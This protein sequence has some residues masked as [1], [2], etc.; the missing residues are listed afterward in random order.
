[1]RNESAPICFEL[2]FLLRW[3]CVVSKPGWYFQFSK[4]IPV[5]KG[6]P[7]VTLRDAGAYVTKLPKAQNDSRVWQNAMHVLIQ[8]ADH[9]GPVE[10]ARLGMM[11]ALY[12][13]GEPV[14]DRPPQAGGTNEYARH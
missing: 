7:L 9:G 14:Y 12:P 1:M 2:R 8:A 3:S 10:F 4:P 5:P 6:E 13:K 11:Q